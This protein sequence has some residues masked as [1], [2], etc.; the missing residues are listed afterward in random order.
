MRVWAIDTVAGTHFPEPYSELRK[1]SCNVGKP[2]AVNG[3][4]PDY[5]HDIQYRLQDHWISE[6]YRLA[7]S[8]Q[9]A[10]IP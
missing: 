9:A 6:G 5:H 4:P 8:T 3:H 7:P 1:R 2:A 10:G